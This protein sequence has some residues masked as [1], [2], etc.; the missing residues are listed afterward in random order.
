MQNSSFKY[1]VPNKYKNYTQLIVVLLILVCI[2]LIFMCRFVKHMSH[3]IDKY[4]V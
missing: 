4:I 1:W 2:V 3:F